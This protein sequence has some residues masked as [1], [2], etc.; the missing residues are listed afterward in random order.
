MFVGS[1]VCFSSISREN[2]ASP[3]A[4]QSQMERG[5]ANRGRVTMPKLCARDGPIDG[6]LTVT[7]AAKPGSRASAVYEVR[8]LGG[9]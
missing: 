5:M 2:L 4:V 6:L 8:L 1:Y 3:H 7:F 9:R